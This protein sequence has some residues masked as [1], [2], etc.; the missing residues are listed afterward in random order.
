MMVRMM[1]FVPHERMTKKLTRNLYETRSTLERG[2]D[3]VFTTDTSL[4]MTPDV[5]GIKN[6]AYT[7][8]GRHSSYRPV[9]TYAQR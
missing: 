1:E 8:P 3:Q 4:Y 2:H 6:K 5:K 7:Q 9:I